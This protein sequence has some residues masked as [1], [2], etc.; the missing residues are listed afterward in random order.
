LGD[1]VLIEPSSAG[2]RLRYVAIVADVLCARGDAV[3]LLT[4]E[5]AANSA[6]WRVHLRSADI[7]V[8]IL[9]VEHF[10]L[11]RLRARSDV[12]NAIRTV[13]LDGDRFLPQLALGKWGGEAQAT[14]LIMRPDAEPRGVPM[15]RVVLGVA[16]RG[17]MVAANM[18]RNVRAVGLRSPL[19]LRRGP[20]AWAP[21]PVTLISDPRAVRAV[22]A[23][24]DRQR[25]RAWVG[26]YGYITPRKN[27][28]LILEA[29]HRLDGVGLMVAGTIDPEVRKDCEGGIEALKASGR[30]VQLPGPLGEETFDAALQVVDCV[31][32]AHSNEGPSGV[33]AK[34]A[35]AGKPL[36]LAGARSFRRDA[37]ALGDQAKWVPLEARD[38]A[39]AISAAVMA[40][41]APTGV[42]AD[43]GQ[44]V[45][46][47]V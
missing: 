1:Y 7:E 47:L 11:L 22:E 45:A 32:A 6:E 31:V 36:V 2:H 37:K 33:V 21:D 17:L 30:Y 42:A 40:P 43:V 25:T 10:D 26:L 14:F 38:L 20:G 5:E 39:E 34:G 3:R 29:V 19:S 13:V 9:P 16:K 46:A 44:F 35:A 23:A 28:P 12:R 27:L 15:A 18:R 4:T 8:E 24:L 41:P